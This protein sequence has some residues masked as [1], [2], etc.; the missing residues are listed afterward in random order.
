[1]CFRVQK[2]SNW[3]LLLKNITGTV[4]IKVRQNTVHVL[5][6]ENSASQVDQILCRVLF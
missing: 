4:W 5:S 6:T 1:M 2:Q 3:P